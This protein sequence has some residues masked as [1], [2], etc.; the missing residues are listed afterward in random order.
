MKYFGDVPLNSLDLGFIFSI[1]WI[2]V[3][4]QRYRKETGKYIFMSYS[5]YEHK[6]QLTRLFHVCLGYLL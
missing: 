5:G 2:F 3:C 6:E 1:F 4:Y